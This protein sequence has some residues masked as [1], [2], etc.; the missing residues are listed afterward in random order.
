MARSRSGETVTNLDMATWATE[1][2]RCPDAFARLSFDVGTDRAAGCA[3]IRRTLEVAR[4]NGASVTWR[5][6]PGPCGPTEMLF[7]IALAGTGEQ[8]ASTVRWFYEVVHG[9]R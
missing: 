9:S 2:E 7:L 1:L 8:L 4:E 5:E 3:D 6:V